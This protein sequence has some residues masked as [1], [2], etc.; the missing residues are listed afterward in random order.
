MLQSMELQ[1]GLHNLMT[2]KQQ[3]MGIE[4]KISMIKFSK[5]S[6]RYLNTKGSR[7]EVCIP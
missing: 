1:R 4:I 3:N 5:F 6:M 2:E 7:E